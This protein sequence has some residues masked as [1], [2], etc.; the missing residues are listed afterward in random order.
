VSGLRGLREPVWDNQRCKRAEPPAAAGF[1][2]HPPW[3]SHHTKIYSATIPLLF[4]Q[5]PSS[6]FGVDGNSIESVCTESWTPT[7]STR[8]SIN[9]NGS[10]NKNIQIEQ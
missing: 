5:C 10:N 2:F 8:K 9:Q 4:I 3:H 1:A 6:T 7:F